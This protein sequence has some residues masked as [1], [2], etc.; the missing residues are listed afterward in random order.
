MHFAVKRPASRVAEDSVGSGDEGPSS[1]RSSAVVP[2]SSALYMTVRLSGWLA[3]FC[4]M[5]AS[6]SNSFISSSDGQSCTDTTDNTMQ[7]A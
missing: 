6:M 5:A 4:R 2:A 7:C 3:K 1:M